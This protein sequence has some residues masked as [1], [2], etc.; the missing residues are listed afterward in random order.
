MRFLDIIGMS[1][2]NLWRRKLRTFLTVLGVVIGTASIVVMIS[3]GIGLRV[4]MVKEASAYGAMN[5]ITVNQMFSASKENLLTDENINKIKEIAYVEDVEPVL[6]MNVR[7]IQGK[8]TIYCDLQ[9]VTDKYLSKLEVGQG[10]LPESKGDMEFLAGNT[11]IAGAYITSTYVYPYYE[12]NE[13]PDID[14]MNKNV[15]TQFDPVT[16]MD[17]SGN[18]VTKQSKKKIFPIVGMIAGEIDDWGVHGNSLYTNLEAL[19][20][21]V[22]KT[23]K[24]SAIPGQPTDKNGRP[25]KNI[26][27]SRAIVTVSDTNMVSDVL[28]TIQEMGY[29]AY[30]EAEWI[31][32]TENS[33]MIIQ[34]VLGGIGAI[35]FFVAAIGI[36]NTMMMSTYERTKEIG[37]MKVLG[38]SLPNIRSLFLA[39]A[40]FI[41]IIGGVTGL[42]ISYILSLI[43]NK[44]IPPMI[45]VPVDKISVIPWWLAV[46]SIVFAAMVGMI[47][48][49]FPAQRATKLSPLAAIRNE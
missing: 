34:A 10:R 8:Y 23:Y 21:Y 38:C 15:Y 20:N 6:S 19:K 37:V 45:D 7:L 17:A 40:G 16:V 44:V 33:M 26:C 14:L 27:Y 28:K 36:T 35:S 48:G 29:S 41:G 22:K 42:I 11:L 2:S 4:A 49:F 24:D 25:Y 32:Q 39:E 12:R 31:K 30:S 9:G 47:A 5:E 18:P 46:T 3:L 13:I 1:V 43:C